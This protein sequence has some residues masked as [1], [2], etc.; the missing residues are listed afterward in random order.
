MNLIVLNPPPFL[1]AIGALAA[2]CDNTIS[3]IEIN[4][5]NSILEFLFFVPIYLITSFLELFDSGLMIDLVLDPYYNIYIQ[6][7]YRQQHIT[8]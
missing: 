5:S 7:I 8:L 1:V 3:I 4:L 6:P 2:A